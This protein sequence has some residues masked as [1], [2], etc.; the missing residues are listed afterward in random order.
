MGLLVLD[1][2]LFTTTN[3]TTAPS[4]IAI[5]GFILLVATV[6]Y[7]IYEIAGLGRLYGLPVH[8]RKS[9]SAYLTVV[10]GLIIAL[11]SIGELG[12]HDILVILPLALIGYL[13]SAYAKAGGR[14]VEG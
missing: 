10:S 13:Y 11:Q 1:I 7:V 4:F 8:H 3:A 12:S 14:N 2:L 5:V 9:L 6:Y